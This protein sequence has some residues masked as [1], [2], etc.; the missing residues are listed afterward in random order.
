M[1]LAEVDIVH[2]WSALGGAE[3]RRR[4]GKAFWR[5]GD[6][7]SVVLDAAKRTWFDHRGGTGGG[8]LALVET[9]LSCSRPQAL[10]WLEA[11][12]ELDSRQSPSQEERAE[13]GRQ[14][15]ESIDARF[16]G[17]AARALTEEA[18]GDLNADDPGRADYTRLIGILRTGGP[19]LIKEYR[20]WLESSPRLTR[21]MVQAGLSSEAR[22]QRR[23]AYYVSE[24]TN[25]A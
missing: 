8:V 17:T 14:V 7:Y 3:L 2:A 6:G 25:E 22:V 16:W 23:L 12:C 9:A 20:V 21:A 5:S 19:G 11:N 24:M 4:R 18:L 10:Q 15:A 13:H 1:N